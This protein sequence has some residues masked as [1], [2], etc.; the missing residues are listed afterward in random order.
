M[1]TTARSGAAVM[2][3]LIAVAAALGLILAVCGGFAVAQPSGL[4][5]ETQ[6]DRTHC[7]DGRGYLSTEERSGNYTHGWDNQGRSWT[8]QRQGDRTYWWRAR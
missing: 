4:T 8:E 3:R 7:W 2:A 6:G 1:T 5:C